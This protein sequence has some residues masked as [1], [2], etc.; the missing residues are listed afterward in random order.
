LKNK[1]E[2]TA[3]EPVQPGIVYRV[4]FRIGRERIKGSSLSWPEQEAESRFSYLSPSAPIS[5]GHNKH[6]SLNQG[7]CVPTEQTEKIGKF[8]TADL[9]MSYFHNQ[10]GWYSTTSA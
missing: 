7:S 2:G 1:T 8:C 6:L 9:L 3:G 5:V 4:F 10:R